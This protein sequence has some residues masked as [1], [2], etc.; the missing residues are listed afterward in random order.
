MYHTSSIRKVKYIRLKDTDFFAQEQHFTDME[1]ERK[2]MVEEE[3]LVVDFREVRPAYGVLMQ[4]GFASFST[5]KRS[6]Q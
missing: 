6:P 1:A 2:E 3:G 5:K 4:H